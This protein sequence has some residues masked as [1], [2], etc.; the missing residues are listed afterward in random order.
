MFHINV[1]ISLEEAVIVSGL[2]QIIF[3]LFI[4]QY[5]KREI[6]TKNL[7]DKTKIRIIEPKITLKNLFWE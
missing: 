4:F 3:S 5:W 6:S 2:P 1:S 7:R